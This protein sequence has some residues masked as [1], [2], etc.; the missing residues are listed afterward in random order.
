MKSTTWPWNPC[1]DLKIRSRRF[2]KAPPKI[3]PNTMAHAVEEIFAENQMIPMQAPNARA[4]KTKVAPV[5]N[6]NAAPEFRANENLT[7]DPSTLTDELFS[8]C[9]TAS[10]FDI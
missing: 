8:K 5:A 1:G 10:A 3:A 6:E 9:M 2:P 4:V 7:S